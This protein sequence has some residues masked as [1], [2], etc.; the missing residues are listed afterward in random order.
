MKK[1]Q[2]IAICFLIL[3][4]SSCSV[5]KKTEQARQQIA[6][7]VLAGINHG[8]I[9]ENTDLSLISNTNNKPDAYSGATKIAYH[10][11]VH[12]VKSLKRNQ[13]ES[14]IDYML[15]HQIFTYNDEENEYNGTRELY[16]R[17]I[18]LPLTYN[19]NI[20]NKLLPDNDVQFKIG[21]IAQLNFVDIDNSGN[22]PQYT[23]KKWSNGLS[24]GVSSSLLSFK[25]GNNI[26][27]YLDI[28]RGSRI[29]EDFY[30][31]PAFEMPGTS[32]AR[33]GLRYQF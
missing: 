2:I 23:L 5:N 13:I 17:Q 19:F 31:R 24:L 3:S 6:F 11:G 7:L 10:T 1:I 26:G 29:Y 12:I 18:M 33:L 30:N 27:F 21:Y 22:L 20:F 32:F 16:V 15:N 4:V 14:G 8:G 25:N 28:Y 9:T